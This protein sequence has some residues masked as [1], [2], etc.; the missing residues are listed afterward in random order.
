[1]PEPSMFFHN[2][3]NE[4]EGRQ[5]GEAFPALVHS[6]AKPVIIIHVAARI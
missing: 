4:E 3:E 6:I 5:R 2:K 1:M